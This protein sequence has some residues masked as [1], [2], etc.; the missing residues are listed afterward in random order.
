MATATRTRAVVSEHAHNKFSCG[1]AE[2]LDTEWKRKEWGGV[3]AYFLGL[4]IVGMARD[5]ANYQG[6]DV[7]ELRYRK[8]FR[9]FSV[10]EKAVIGKKMGTV[11]GYEI[12][13]YETEKGSEH[14]MITHE[15]MY[16]RKREM[17]SVI[18]EPRIEGPRVFF[19][20]AGEQ[21]CALAVTLACEYYRLG[22]SEKGTNDGV[23][24]DITDYT[25]KGWIGKFTERQFDK[26]ALDGCRDAFQRMKGSVI[27]E[28][29]SMMKGDL[30]KAR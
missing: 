14:L 6:E 30:G 15:D 22:I 11:S 1:T 26:Q 20:H 29:I 4:G 27:K 10:E 5:L 18:I 17:L 25:M 19:E 8:R 3:E 9:L 21:E 24:N 23:G 7:V 16:S 2:L 28:K 13:L 12:S